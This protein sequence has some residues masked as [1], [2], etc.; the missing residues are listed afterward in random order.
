MRF[1]ETSLKGAYVVEPELITDER[2]MFARSFCRKEFEM[3]GLN[4]QLVQCNISFNKKKGTLRGMHYQQ[5][6]YAEVKL[7]R[8]TMGA[9]YDVIL[10][11]RPESPTFKQWSF[12]N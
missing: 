12:L 6:P 3:N 9:I 8:C 10:D 7:V 4:P 2:G 1:I 11:I 5:T